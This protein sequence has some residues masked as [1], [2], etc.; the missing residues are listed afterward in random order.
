METGDTWPPGILT[1][2]LPFNAQLGRSVKLTA[3]SLA[4]DKA[5][6]RVR[7]QLALSETHRGVRRA[8]ARAVGVD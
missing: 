5:D 7:A 1:F 3:A 8:R 6:S 4:A 2:V